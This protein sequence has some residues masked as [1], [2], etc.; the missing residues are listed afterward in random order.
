MLCDAARFS[1]PGSAAC[2]CAGTVAETFAGGVWVAQAASQ[3]GMQAQA[4][5][6]A[7]RLNRKLRPI[8]LSRGEKGRTGR[9]E[10]LAS[11]CRIDS[12]IAFMASFSGQV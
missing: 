2:H 6:D 11:S 4:I 9:D 8:T 3:K 5:I 7:A 1:A 12:G 10:D